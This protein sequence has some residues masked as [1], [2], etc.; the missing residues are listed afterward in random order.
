ME[1]SSK[2]HAEHLVIEAESLARDID[3]GLLAYA[4]PDARMEWA[5][6]R[7]RWPWA[8]SLHPSSP[9]S[10]KDEDLAVIV[11]KVRRFRAILGRGAAAVTVAPDHLF[12]Q[13]IG[14]FD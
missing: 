3:D 6:L 14:D 13:A 10:S 7:A 11:G 9:I 4:S 8:S 5:A 2:T 12:W 1:N